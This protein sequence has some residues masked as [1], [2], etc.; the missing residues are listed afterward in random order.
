[1]EINHLASERCGVLGVVDPDAYAPAASIATGWV[2]ASRFHNLMAV[3]MAGDLGTACTLDGTLEEA[4]SSAGA[5]SQAIA[6]KS[7]TLL[8]QAGTDSN[9]QAVINLK[10]AELS[11]GYRYVRLVLTHADTTSP[12]NAT[13]DAAGILVGIDPVI[14]VATTF[15]STTVDEVVA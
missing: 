7:I 13:S 12:M 6:G 1:M 4:T 14:G 9:K 8:T 11:P 3:V 2:D 10:P 15:D 5:G